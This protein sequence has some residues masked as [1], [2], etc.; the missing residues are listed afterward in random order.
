M[1]LSLDDGRRF[2]SR[3]VAGLDTRSF[4]I[5]ALVVTQKEAVDAP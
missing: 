1:I 2:G 3:Q 4:V 5:G